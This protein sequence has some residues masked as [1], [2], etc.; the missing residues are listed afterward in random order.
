MGLFIFLYIACF[1][2][3]AIAFLGGRGKKTLEV[4]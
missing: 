2:M 1:A 4:R 3:F